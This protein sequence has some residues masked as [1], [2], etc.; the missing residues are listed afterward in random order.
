VIIEN[1]HG[2]VI[3]VTVTVDRAKGNIRLVPSESGVTVAIER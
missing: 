3:A 1:Q 2:V